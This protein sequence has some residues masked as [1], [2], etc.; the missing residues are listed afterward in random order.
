MQIVVITLLTGGKFPIDRATIH[1]HRRT[2]LHPVGYKTE[3]TKL[4]G[5]PGRCRFGNTSAIPLVAPHVH[6]SVKEC[7]SREHYGA[8][9]EFDSHSRTHPCDIA[10]IIDHKLCHIVLPHRQA[11]YI[12]KRQA[13]HL[14]EAHPVRLRTRAPHSRTFRAVQHTELY[15]GAVCDYTHHATESIDLTHYLTFRNTTHSRIAAHLGNLVHV[16]GDQ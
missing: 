2:G 15:R 9:L 5:Q 14:T 12:F 11:G 4:S 16:E 13:P 6:L 8:S 10:V 3:L 1:T 7:A